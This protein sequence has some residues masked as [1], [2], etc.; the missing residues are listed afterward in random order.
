MHHPL[1]FVDFKIKNLLPEHLTKRNILE[2][3]N[4]YLSVNC[5]LC[6]SSE[7]LKYKSYLILNINLRDSFKDMNHAMGECCQNN[8]IFNQI[9]IFVFYR[10]IPQ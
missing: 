7:C 9:I 4:N 8:A 10:R 3:F 5:R 6:H 1:L 2:N